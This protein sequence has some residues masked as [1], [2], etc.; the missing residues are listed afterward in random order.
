ML[1]LAIV[2]LVCFSAGWLAMT[3]LLYSFLYGSFAISYFFLWSEA[4]RKIFAPKGFWHEIT[5]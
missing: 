3:I 5:H 4:E 2:A 1:Y